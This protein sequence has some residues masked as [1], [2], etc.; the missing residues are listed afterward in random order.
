[1]EKKRKVIKIKAI[2]AERVEKELII[3][4]EFIKLDSALK[5]A[6]E[7]ET[8]GHAKLMVSEGKVFVNGE[9]CLQRGKKLFDGDSFRVGATVYKVVRLR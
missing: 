9:R 6:G 7:A 8:G 3:T 5:L 1:M 2:P 4:T